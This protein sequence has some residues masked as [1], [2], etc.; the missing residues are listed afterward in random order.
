MK[1][2]HTAL[3]VDGC[4]GVRACT[5]VWFM[6]AARLRVC[7]YVREEEDSP[8]SGKWRRGNRIFPTVG[9][10]N[11]NPE[12]SIAA[13]WNYLRVYSPSLGGPTKPH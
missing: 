7:A 12:L 10:S 6:L 9:L 3:P 13:K 4:A 1:H 5:C 11:R 2:T 8:K